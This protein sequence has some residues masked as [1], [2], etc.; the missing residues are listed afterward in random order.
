MVSS[1]FMNTFVV[2]LAAAASVSN[3]LPVSLP[4]LGVGNSTSNITP[5]VPSNVPTLPSNLP[6]VPSTIPSIAALAATTTTALPDL[7]KGT[8]TILPGSEDQSKHNSS[9]RV[10]DP[11]HGK[12]ANQYTHPSQEAENRDNWKDQNEKH[13]AGAD[14][15]EESDTSP[16]KS[17]EGEEGKTA[18]DDSADLSS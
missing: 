16:A 5:T 13:R 6:T 7:T 14:N 8:P 17:S 3:A 1:T 2:A 12:G 10:A 11:K 15:Q 18:G 4:D 9:G